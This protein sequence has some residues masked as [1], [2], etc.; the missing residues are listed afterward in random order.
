MKKLS[1]KRQT[2]ELSTKRK[3][4]K[5]SLPQASPHGVVWNTRTHES[6]QHRNHSQ[7]ASVVAWGCLD[8]SR[9]HESPHRRHHSQPYMYVRLYTHMLRIL[10]TCATDTPDAVPEVLWTRINCSPPIE[11]IHIIAQVLPQRSGHTSKRKRPS[12]RSWRQSKLSGTQTTRRKL[13]SLMQSTTVRDQ[14]PADSR[15]RK[16][17][18]TADNYTIPNQNVPQFAPAEL[19]PPSSWHIPISEI[20]LA[21]TACFDITSPA[22]RMLRL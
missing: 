1:T 12:S 15:G 21:S 6:P 7:P 5:L 4:K 2:K 18:S 17:L 16:I 3:T 10:L 19:I 11:N 9:A 8:H 14:R 22:T 13:P 20:A